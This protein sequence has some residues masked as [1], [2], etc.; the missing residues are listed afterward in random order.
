MRSLVVGARPT[1]LLDD[2]ENHPFQVASQLKCRDADRSK[3]TLRYP[4]VPLR[5]TLGATAT[6]MRLAINLDCEPGREACEVQGERIERTLPP[7]LESTRPT[8]EFPP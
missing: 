6:I 1:A 8:T 2:A 7:E 3:A 4:P 5:I